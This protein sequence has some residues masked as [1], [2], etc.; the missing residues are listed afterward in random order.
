MPHYILDDQGWPKIRSE[1]PLPDTVKLSER[2]GEYYRWNGEEWTE[3]ADRKM[4]D[5]ESESLAR[6]DAK[7]S[8]VR[9]HFITEGVGQS[10]V[11]MAKYEEAQAYKADNTN[12]VPHLDAEAKRRGMVVDALAD[13][14]IATRAAWTNPASATIEAERVGGKHDVRAASDA[15]SKHAAADNAIAALDAITP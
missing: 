15:D 8:E 6:I 12:D 11:Y 13:E 2:P 10:A 7:A 5:V 3:D 1:K 4:A 14:V 9:S